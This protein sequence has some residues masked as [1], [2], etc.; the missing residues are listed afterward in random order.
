MIFGGLAGATCLLFFV[1]MYFTTPNPLS[2]RRPDL[3]FNILFVFVGIWY[4]KKKNG[5]YIHFYEAFSVGFLSN[6]FAALVTGTGLYAFVSLIDPSPFNQWIAGG[7]QFL[8]DQKEA[9]SNIL[10]EE[11]FKLQLE[12]FDKA[13]PAQLFW[14]EIIF[15]QFGIIAV[16]LI[17]MALRKNK[18]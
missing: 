11:N 1:A 17:S 18:P 6:L 3:F 2:L 9:M 7:R 15:K 5:G 8:I 4:A 12:A 16:S 10:S 14:D 13:H